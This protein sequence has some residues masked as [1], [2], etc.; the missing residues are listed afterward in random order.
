M[1]IVDFLVLLRDR[2]IQVFAEGDRLRCNAPARALTPELREELR[3]R[4]NEILKFLRSAESLAGQQRAIIP[5]QPRGA[6][7]PVF[8]VAGHNGD[9]FCFRSLAH[10]LGGDQPFF[11]LQPPGLDG[12]SEPLDRVEDL[13]AYFAAQIQSV[14]PGGPCIIAGYCA[15]GTIA[16]E[17]ARQLVHQR[18]DVRLLA[19][20][21]SPFPTWYRFGPQIQDCLAQLADR[22]IRHSRTLMSL[23]AAQQ[24]QYLSERLRGRQAERAHK[25]PSAEDPV[26][27]WRERVGRTTL[28]AIRRYNPA[29]FSGRLALFWPGE[30]WRRAR[31]APAKWMKLAPDSVK[32]AGPDGSNGSDML[33]EPYAAS[34]ARL[35]KATL[36]IPAGANF[37]RSESGKTLAPLTTLPLGKPGSLAVSTD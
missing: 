32:L 25:Q 12:S 37:K 5:L 23:S 8:A 31:S 17:L 33:R 14:R 3:Q 6:A 16:L 36:E 28:A 29:P 13:A 20:F 19:L 10:H 2:D 24:W 7:G 9:V 35:F 34:F 11:G 27:V 15:G 4:K 18:V 21:G 26:I 30:N 1:K 22:A